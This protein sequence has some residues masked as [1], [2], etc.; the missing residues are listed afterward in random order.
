MAQHVDYQLSFIISNELPLATSG[1]IE[2]LPEL[3]E[4][5]SL[6]Q[7]NSISPAL[8]WAPQRV[9]DLFPALFAHPVLWL[10]D[11]TSLS[12][13]LGSA[14]LKQYQVLQWHRVTTY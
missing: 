3:M 1:S 8:S 7:L 9:T 2:N 10:S 4:D 5:C 11:M 13:F 14:F 12:V 6:S